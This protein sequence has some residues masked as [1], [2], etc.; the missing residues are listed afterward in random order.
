M[1]T[2]TFTACNTHST[3][4]CTTGESFTGSPTNCPDDGGAPPEETFWAPIRYQW[5]V[6]GCCV[7]NISVCLRV[8][9]WN[10]SFT[11]CAAPS[12]CFRT[13]FTASANSNSAF[14]TNGSGWSFS[15]S[16]SSVI[17]RGAL[18][19]VARLTSCNCGPGQTL[20]MKACAE[21]QCCTGGAW[22]TIF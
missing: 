11:S 19:G 20:E 21:V 10:G 2:F 12:T 17:A 18:G 22:Q 13:L 16:C 5:A 8:E 6:L 1:E 3:G 9:Q 15:G 14:N 4:Q 7:F